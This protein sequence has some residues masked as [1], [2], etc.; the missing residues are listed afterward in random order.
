MHSECDTS[1][2]PIPVTITS[3]ASNGSD[4]GASDMLRNSS[5]PS[6]IPVRSGVS[7]TPSWK[8]VGSPTTP[9]GFLSGSFN[10][11]SDAGFLSRSPALNI[12]SY[13]GADVDNGVRGLS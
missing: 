13:T 12:G 8:A 1:R 7:P 11:N 4:S 6:P 3:E 5:I 9:S 2:S 10:E